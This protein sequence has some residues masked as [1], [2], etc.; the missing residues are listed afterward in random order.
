MQKIELLRDYYS[1]KRKLTFLEFDGQFHAHFDAI[2]GNSSVTF[3]GDEQGAVYVW[4]RKV[5]NGKLV[6]L[7]IGRGKFKHYKG[8]QILSL[9]S[10]QFYPEIEGENVT[11]EQCCSE[12]QDFFSKPSIRK[13]SNGKR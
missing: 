1:E 12:E 11:P 7:L 4:P 8:I 9:N 2:Y 10:V 5:K 6:C 3:G 13:N